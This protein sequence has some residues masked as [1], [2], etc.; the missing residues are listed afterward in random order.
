MRGYTVLTFIILL[1]LATTIGSVGAA[2]TK[3]VEVTAGEHLR[4]QTPVTL[5]MPND[6]AGAGGW[7]LTR[8]DDGVVVPVQQEVGNP[9]ALTWLL[10]A[11][12]PAGSSRRYRLQ[13]GE[14]GSTDRPQLTCQRD[15]GTRWLQSGDRRALGYHEAIQVAPPGIDR[16]YERSGYIH[17]LCTPGGCDVTDDFPPDHAHQHGVF[18]AW[19]KAT[20]D[21]H[22]V[23]FWNQR[24]GTG[25]V[26][27][28][29]LLG[30]CNGPVFAEF[31]VALQ[32]SDLTAPAGPRPVL[33]ETWTVRLYHVDQAYLID[34]ESQQSCAGNQ[35]L[36]IHKHHYGGLAIRGSR[37]WFD[38]DAER[39]KR[40]GQPSQFLTSEGKGRVEGNHTRPVWV[41]LSGLVDG[42]PCGLAVMGHP[43]NHG[44]PQPVRLHPTKPY[45]CF[46]PMY[47]GEMRIRP[48]QTYVSR[49]RFLVHDGPADAS[50][51]DR[52]WHDYADPSQVVLVE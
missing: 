4:W 18:F 45:F 50:F 52:I 1:S 38:A 22:G 40:K 5:T 17:P 9:R 36:A 13:R 34:L 30:Q 8:I 42:R 10:R 47:L 21:G 41:S 33:V 27:H 46:A 49:Y 14:R 26:A 2:E 43:S 31:Q 12:L 29:R 25:G 19:V 48:G 37:H 44:F 39:E 7:Q 28:H 3:I 23:D 32:H 51:A 35:P 24:G 15:N 11:P 20:F 6:V 16:V